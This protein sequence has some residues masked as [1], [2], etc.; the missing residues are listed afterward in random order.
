MQGRQLL[1]VD[2]VKLLDEVDEVLQAR[3]HVGLLPERHNLGSEILSAN[4]CS[5]TIYLFEVLMVDMSVHSEEPL[6]N[7][8]GDG[9]EV[10]G[11]GSA[12]LAGEHRL[13]LNLE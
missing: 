9:Q 6:E 8:L 4:N 7:E 2:Q 1:A 10:P 13:V 5:M 11:E 12:D 3:V